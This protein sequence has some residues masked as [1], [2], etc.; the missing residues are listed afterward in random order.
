VIHEFDPQFNYRVTKLLAR[1]GAFALLNW[2]DDRTWYPLGRIVG[3]TVYPGLMLAAAAIHW[4]VSF[5]SPLQLS[6][7]HACV[8]VAPVFA[9]FSC[10]AIFLL[11]RDVTRSTLTGLL[12]AALIGISP[13]YISRS[14]AGSFDNEGVAIFLLI[15]TFYLW[16]KAV[17]TGSMLVSALAALSYFAMAFSWGG[18]VFIINVIP[19]HVVALLF[20]RNYSTRV[21]VAYSTFYPI[22][23]LLSMQVPFIGFN[24]V[25]KGEA[26]ASHG[27]FLLLQGTHRDATPR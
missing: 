26:A 11:T 7:R 12:A 5:F 20:S 9:A 25:L 3:T 24:A 16:V 21:Y 10:V 6:V 19:I 14:T 1:D 8:M 22:A 17:R 23:T 15:F 4:G 27:V 18:Y 2:F 13:A